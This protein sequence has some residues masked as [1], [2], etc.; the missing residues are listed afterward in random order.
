LLKEGKALR[1]IYEACP[2]AFGHVDLIVPW[3]A[4][5]A[6][7]RDLRHLDDVVLEAT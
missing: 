1:V 3:R 7:L 4:N 6:V 5:F 2:S